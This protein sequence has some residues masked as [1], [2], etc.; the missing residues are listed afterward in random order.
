MPVAVFVSVI[1]SHTVSEVT[2]TVDP[3]DAPEESQSH[4]AGG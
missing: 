3:G 4:A 1:G 2:V